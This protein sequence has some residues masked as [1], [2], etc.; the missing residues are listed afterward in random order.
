MD[1]VVLP[2]TTCFY[3]VEFTIMYSVCLA[4]EVNGSHSVSANCTVLTFMTC[5]C[6]VYW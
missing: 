3:G 4:Y 5:F 6:H 2:F 1:R